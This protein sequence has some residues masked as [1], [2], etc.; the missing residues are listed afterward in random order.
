MSFDFDAA[1]SSPFRMQ[2]GLRKLQ[3]GSA[4]LTPLAPGSAH[5]REKL[6]VLPIA[7]SDAAERHG[8]DA[9]G[10]PAAYKGYKGDSNYCIEIWRDEKGKW[11]SDVISTFAA[12]QIVRE[13]GGNTSRLRHAALS[14][15]GKPL[16]MRLMNG[17]LLKAEFKGSL[18]VL[19]VC[20][21]KSVG[22]IF[23]ADHRE[24]NIRAR[25]DAK[26][27]TLIYGSFTAASLQKARG[28]QVF[29]SP[30]GDLRDPG[31]DG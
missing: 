26:D 6:A 17:D 27:E 16:V 4:Q 9:N 23:V 11:R 29:A 14:Q 18:R 10:E 13:C 25:E 8:V 3:L 28:R 5:Q 7:R 19:Q 1:V 22:A 20:K 2:P 21:I 24:A 30:I 12:N 31:F 15:G